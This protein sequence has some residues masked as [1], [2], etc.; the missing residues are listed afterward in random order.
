MYKKVECDNAFVVH[1]GATMFSVLTMEDEYGG[2]VQVSI[3]DGCYV[4]YLKTSGAGYKPT[5]WIFD[6]LH[7]EM[8]KLPLPMEMQRKRLL[9]AT[10]GE[11]ERE[12][13]AKTI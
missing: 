10:V 4:A 3:D 13:N 1:N 12:R 11:I 6:E 7:A 2:R 8:K 9:L 5:S